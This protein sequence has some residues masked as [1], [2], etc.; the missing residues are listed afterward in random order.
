MKAKAIITLGLPASGK[1]TF[2]EKLGLTNQYTLFDS[3]TYTELTHRERNEHMCRDLISFV[4]NEGK[5][6]I[7]A[8][9][10]GGNNFEETLKWL[11]KCEYKIIILYFDTEIEICRN[12]NKQRAR[13]VPE[14]VFI[15][16]EETLRRN[17]EISHKYADAVYSIM[18]DL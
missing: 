18:P 17:V 5:D 10:T 8:G 3:D 16:G 6:L 11:T 1:S 12:L 4:C 9:A 7:I 2:I 13:M 15:G 14:Y